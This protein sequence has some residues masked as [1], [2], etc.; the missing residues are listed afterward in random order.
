MI[1]SEALRFD[2]LQPA[3]SITP[4]IGNFALYQQRGSAWLFNHQTGRVWAVS[5]PLAWLTS[6]EKIA[7]AREEVLR[8]EA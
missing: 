3:A 4:I 6:E 1:A 5:E 2:S 8:G 7:H